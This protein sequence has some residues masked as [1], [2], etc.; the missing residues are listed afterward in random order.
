MTTSQSCEEKILSDDVMRSPHKERKN[1]SQRKKDRFEEGIKLWTAFYR[2]NMHRFATD[3]LKLNLYPF[4]L[5]MLYMMNTMYSVCFICAR[6]LSKSYTTAIFLCCK[7]ILY[8]NSLILVSCTTKEQARTLIREKINKELMKKSPALRR[9]IEDIRIGTNETIVYFRN[10][11]TIQ[12]INASQNT[13][14]MRCHVLVVDEYRMIN[15]EFE[16]LNSV[17]RQFLNCVRIPKFKNR[18]DGKYENYPPEENSEIYLSSAWYGDHWSYDL[19]MQ[20]VEKMLKGKDY[21]ACNLPYQLSAY[22]GLLTKKRVED[23]RTN[24]SMT[25]MVFQMELEALFYK[26]NDHAYFKASDILPLRTLEFAW[27]PPTIEEYAEN[28]S[29]EKKSYHLKRLSAKELRILSCDIAL[30]DSKN[31]KNN[32]N[33][34]FTFMRAL[35]KNENYITQVLWS[36]AHEGWKARELALRIKQL[37]FDSQSDYIVLDVTGLGLTVLD[38]LGE[39]TQD[40]ERGVIYPPLKAMEEEKYMCRCEYSEAQK[41]IYPVCATDKFNHDIATMLKTSF[42]NETIKFMKNQVEAEDFIEGYEKLNPE[43]QAKM[44]MPYIQTSLM[45]N[46]I[47]ALEYEVKNSYIRIFET[48]S[49]TKDRYSSLAYGNY[50]IRRKMEGKLKKKKKGGLANLW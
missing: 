42:Q 16:T 33:A 20:H 45:Q 10:G 14:G 13:R 34:V 44:L 49:N 39:Y 29:K 7:A 15:G 47:I 17:L 46:E 18:K 35:P 2:L 26:S 25:D 28:K 1:L 24:E 5:I 38:E 27:Y 3:Y 22:H 43:L 50:F 40:T 23:M 9:E 48:G 41:C 30:M 37:Y 8:P 32:D 4:Q 11:S 31:G 6:G 21:F 19:Y 12:A 36:E